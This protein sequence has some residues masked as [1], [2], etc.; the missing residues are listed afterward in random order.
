M[1]DIELLREAVLKVVGPA[2]ASAEAH[3]KA[4]SFLLHKL[5]N[6]GTC[7]ESVN[8]DNWAECRDLLKAAKVLLEAWYD[9]PLGPL[10]DTERFVPVEE[11]PGPED[12]EW[13]EVIFEGFRGVPDRLVLQRQSGCWTDGDND[14]DPLAW[15]RDKIPRVTH[16]RRLRSVPEEL[17]KCRR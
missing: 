9:T 1:N 13:A 14:R 12:E 6:P 2:V 17:L 10:P 5:Q 3:G 8:A 11:S 15:D 7:D 4:A 16:W